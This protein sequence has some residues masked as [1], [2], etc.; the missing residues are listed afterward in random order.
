MKRGFFRF[1]NLGG[2]YPALA[3]DIR[4]GTPLAV[5]GVSEPHRYFLAGLT[6]FPV[7]YLTA[8][9]PS[10][11][12][13]AEAI[14]VLSGKRVT[15]LSAKDEVLLYK[16]TLSKDALFKRL[17]ALAEF[18]SGT[19]IVVAD[20]E[21]VLQ[22]FPRSLPCLV[23]REGEEYDFLKLPSRL[24]QMGYTRSYEVEYPGTF[25]VR[26]DILDLYPVGGAHPLR[27]DFFGD[28]VEH[29]KP[30]EMETGERLPLV[31]EVEIPAASDT[32]LSPGD[33]ERIVETLQKE[34]KAAKTMQAYTRKNAIAE[35]IAA[36]LEGGITAS[37]AAL[38]YVFPL[39]QNSCDFFSLL[40]ENTVL[41]FDECK[42]VY[43]K[44]DG[45]YKEHEERFSEL[46]AGGEV[47]SFHKNQ[48]ISRESFFERL[49]AFRRVALG[50]FSGRLFFFEPL[51][52]YNFPSSPVSR[53]LNSF[54]LLFNDL[55]TWRINGYRVLVFCGSNAREEKLGAA[56]AEQE[57]G[58]QELPE[59]L[60]A[61]RGIA[62]SP[63]ALFRGMILHEQKLVLLGSGDLFTAAT[64][65]K[66]LKRRRG[67]LFVAPEIGDYAVH[68]THGI[69]KIIGTKKI[70]TTDSTKEYIAL[71]YKGGDTLYVPVEQMDILSK[72]MGGDAPVLSKIGGAEF[73]RVKARL[74]ASLKKLAF[75]LKA[76]Y[77]ERTARHGFVFPEQTEL[78]EEFENAFPYP[79]TPDQE[80]SVREIKGDMCSEK[81]MDR[82]LC[83]D[84]G[85]G[86]TE[87]AL[88]AVYLCVLGNKQ[89][90]LLCP[91]TILS[92]QHFR[93]ASERFAEFGVRVECLNR[94]RSPK[95]QEEILARLKAGKVDFI[96]GTHRL[97]S[98]DVEFQDL[99]LLVLDEE[100]RFGVE[101]KEQIKNIKKNVDCL[102][103]TATPIPRTLHMSLAGIRDIS[104]IQTPPSARLP[105]QTYVVEEQDTLIRDACIRELSRGGQV[106]ILYNRVESIFTFAQRISDL[107][108]EGK[109]IVGHGRMDQ[110][111]L[112]DNIFGFYRGETNILVTTTIIENGID[113]P[114]ANTLI[115]IDADKLG[116]AQLYQLRGR[117]GRG[118]RL[119]HAYFTYK[120]ERVMT[121][122]ASERL[123]AILEFTE[124]GS[125]YKIAMRDLEI[126]GAGNVLGAEQHGHMDKVGY[127]LYNKLLKEELTGEE[128]TVAELDI[129]ATAF[130]PESYIESSAGR[131]DTYK[132]IAEIKTLEDYKRVC[133]SIEETYGEMP[134][135]VINLLVIAA[136]KSYALKFNVKKISVSTALGAI[137][138]P[139]I[140]SLADRRI[141]G[142]IEAYRD[143]VT[144]NMSA[145]PVIE[146]RIAK[147]SYK[148]M[149][150]MTKFLK[151]ALSLPV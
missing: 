5:F 14:R 38:S 67:D 148:T 104:T 97:L 66:R 71:E 144:L 76:L 127:E 70:Q 13:A 52:L 111:V 102:T 64:P 49:T 26:G 77:A 78:M 69:G 132:Q 19:D 22:L 150:M 125:G 139:S 141:A 106:F 151:F 147:D 123:R 140:R 115:V 109:V 51:R 138:L 30:Y 143:Y 59:N 118:S 25:A 24:V 17:A 68:E 32:I 34:C 44:L 12:R 103:M 86:K 146:F 114:N 11:Q 116:I 124:L 94:F 136:L 41:F 42:L 96:I 133:G 40:P 84:V 90:A 135:E 53:Y 20:I 81:V 82:L 88:R 2:E 47:F 126:R 107:V 108:P 56:L 3:D 15:L 75:D 92:E 7:V 121:T 98:K 93:T 37:D 8:D 131:L 129:K 65:R 61:L 57:I 35:E 117:V 134:A 9:A 33:A 73:E 79:A 48:L 55:R 113:L 1:D 23:L 112:E 18:E 137:E 27:M 72:Y 110:R 43:D 16:N 105:V 122:N 87:V 100:Q 28:T 45:V 101:H 39:L 58:E 29:I 62:L 50:Q 128:Q 6:E 36:K 74:K 120:P 60:N 85:F 31:T 99:G 4:R 119:A 142:A 46:S 10:A 130:I 54:E 91:S 21:A 89:A 80:D 145:A 149:L 63:E 83:G 95:Q